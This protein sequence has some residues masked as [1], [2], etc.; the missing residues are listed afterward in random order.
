MSSQKS[1]TQFFKPLQSGG[2]KRSFSEFVAGSKPIVDAKTRV[3]TTETK[4]VEV[5]NSNTGL[6]VLFIT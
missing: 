4:S 3:E 5:S 6:V 1:L 2:V